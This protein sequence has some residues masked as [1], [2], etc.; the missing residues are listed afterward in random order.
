MEIKGRECEEVKIGED[1]LYFLSSF[2]GKEYRKIMEI[3]FGEDT[4]MSAKGE[5]EFNAGRLIARVPD[6]FPVFCLDIVKGEE[7]VA[8][9]VEY[10]DNLEVEHYVK[11]QGILTDKMAEV[12][13]SKKA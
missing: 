6:L 11:I 2:K 9:S 13:N 1:K 7:H 12:A 10:L 3:Q 5:V 4:K 8:P